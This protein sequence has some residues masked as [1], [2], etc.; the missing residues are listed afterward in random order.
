MLQQ[1]ELVS[2]GDERSCPIL[3]VRLRLQEEG[4]GFPAAPEHF[5][6]VANEE[7]WDPER[8]VSA[9]VSDPAL[10]FYQK[11]AFRGASAAS[12]EKCEA[13]AFEERAQRATRMRVR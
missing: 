11:H 8:G 2:L 5:L 7:G 6:R 1:T 10:H 13:R 9:A 4:Y 12:D 3:R